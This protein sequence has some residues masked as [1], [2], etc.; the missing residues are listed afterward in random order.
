MEVNKDL[1]E[2]F[3]LPKPAGALVAQIMPGGP[4]DKGGLKVGD[5]ILEFNGHEVVRSSDLPHA[6]G[7]VRPG[8]EASLV[9]MRDKERKT[10]RMEV[11]ALNNADGYYPLPH[12]PLQ[13]AM[14]LM[15]RRVPK[16]QGR[17]AY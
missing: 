17:V 9:V 2:S 6:V 3:E 1:A 13:C 16:I 7:R 14:S 10:L 12:A 4:A 11:G 15:V 5:V 8:A